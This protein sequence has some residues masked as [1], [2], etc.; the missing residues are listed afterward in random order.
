MSSLNGSLLDPNQERCRLLLEHSLSQ[1]SSLFSRLAYLAVLRDQSDDVYQD[2]LA[3]RICGRDE[4]DRVLHR[5]HMQAFREWLSLS[6]E[7]QHAELAEYFRCK[8]KWV[9]LEAWTELF[10]FLVPKDLADVERKLFLGDLE[11]T[12]GLLYVER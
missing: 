9:L 3:S 7:R 1:V 2:H 4:V 8:D 5:L 11:R 12:L 6:L 10:Q